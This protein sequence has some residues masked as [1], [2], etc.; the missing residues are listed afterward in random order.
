MGVM[1]FGF[2]FYEVYVML[3]VAMNWI[4]V[5]SNSGEGG[6]DE[7]CFEC[8]ENGDW[9]CFVIKQ[10]ALGWFGVMSY[11]LINVDELQIKMVQGVKFGEGG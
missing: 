9:E 1:F 6:E 4:G 7:V 10:V 2:I 11:Y 5:K 8:K 3:V